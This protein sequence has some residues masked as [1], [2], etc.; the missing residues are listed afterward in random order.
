ME[1]IS[2]ENH[3]YNSHI[4][5]IKKLKDEYKELVEENMV[6]SPNTRTRNI[7]HIWNTERKMPP[8]L[9]RQPCMNFEF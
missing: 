2:E 8:S 3:Q 7:K 1:M 5:W 9:E 6:F 4:E